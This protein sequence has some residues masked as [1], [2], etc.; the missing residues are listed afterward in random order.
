MTESLVDHKIVSESKRVE[1]GK[2][3]LKKEKDSQPYATTLFSKD[4][5]CLG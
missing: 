3:L 4:A 1:S 2:T 5:I